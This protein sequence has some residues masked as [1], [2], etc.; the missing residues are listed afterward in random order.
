MT[1]FTKETLFK[2]T[3]AESKQATTDKT[4]RKMLDT[5]AAARR[6]KTDRLREMRL[7]TVEGQDD[8]AVKDTPPKKTRRAAKRA[9]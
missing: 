9:R 4:V 5:E 8:G 3:R 2:P 7:A 6:A 1:Q